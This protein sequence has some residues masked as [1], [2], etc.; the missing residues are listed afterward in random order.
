MDL[1]RQELVCLAL[2]TVPGGLDHTPVPRRCTVPGLTAVLA[3]A[4]LD[5]SAVALTL[6]ELAAD[7]QLESGI[8]SVAAAGED[9][10]A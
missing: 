5:E 4:G 6:G 2:D 10:Q 3:S 9:G 1:S 7:G 8:R